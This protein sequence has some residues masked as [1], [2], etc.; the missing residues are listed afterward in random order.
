MQRNDAKGKMVQKKEWTSERNKL[1]DGK[2]L[3]EDFTGY[4]L[5][6]RVK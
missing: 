4:P 5:S 3:T 6:Y 2:S 1:E